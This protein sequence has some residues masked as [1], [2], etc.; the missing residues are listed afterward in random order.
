M[1]VFLAMCWVFR[2]WFGIVYENKPIWSDHASFI[3]FL[4]MAQM[5]WHRQSFHLLALSSQSIRLTYPRILRQ[6]ALQRWF[7]VRIS[8]TISNSPNGR[9]KDPQNGLF[10]VWT[11]L[12]IAIFPAESNGVPL[13]SYSSMHTTFRH[14]QIQMIGSDRSQPRAQR[15]GSQSPDKVTLAYCYIKY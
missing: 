8:Q 3:W 2:L 5:C 1:T 7:E 9:G 12:N 10:M 4:I 11:C 15:I 14:A 6:K 13:F